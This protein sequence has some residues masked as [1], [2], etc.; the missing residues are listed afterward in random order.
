MPAETM[1]KF[2]ICEDTCKGM[3]EDILQELQKLGNDPKIFGSMKEAFEQFGWLQ[4]KISMLYIIGY[5]NNE[6]RNNW[7]KMFSEIKEKIKNATYNF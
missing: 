1:K 6:E 5:I 7:K 4:G 3:A 2:G